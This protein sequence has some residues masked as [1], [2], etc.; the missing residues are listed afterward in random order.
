MSYYWNEVSIDF[1]VPAASVAS[2]STRSKKNYFDLNIFVSYWIRVDCH[3]KE[4]FL[5]SH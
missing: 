3:D 2:G 5:F 4:N 1:K